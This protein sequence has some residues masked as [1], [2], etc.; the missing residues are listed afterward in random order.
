M[1]VAGS[2]LLFGIGVED[3]AARTEWRTLA[4]D[5]RFRD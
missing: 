2:E 5:K 3:A 1:S 4:L